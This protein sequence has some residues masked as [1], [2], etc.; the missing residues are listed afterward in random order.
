MEIS[1]STYVTTNN[2]REVRDEWTDACDRAG[3]R[4]RGNAFAEIG[5]A[6]QFGMP[7]DNVFCSLAVAFQIR[8]T[9]EAARELG[10]TV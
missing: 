5:H 1:L 9:I 4:A 3:L 8:G 7:V 2:W 10:I 6:E